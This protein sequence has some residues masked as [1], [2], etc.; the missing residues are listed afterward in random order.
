MSQSL[1]SERVYNF[2]AGP[3]VL[4]EEVL[5]RI[6]DEMMC[7]PGAGSSILEISHR[8]KPFDAI[9]EG[10][11]QRLRQLLSISDDYSVLFL[12]GGSRLQFSM[13]PMNISTAERPGDYL[14][15]GS[16]S[17]KAA[18]EAARLSGGRVIFD[19][20]PDNFCRV[21]ESSE[22]ENNSDRS[23]LYYAANETIQGVQFQDLPDGNDLVSDLSSEFLS[24]P[25][26]VDRHA[27]IYACAQKNAGPAGLTVVIIRKSLLEQVPDNL[28]AYLNFR[29]HDSN[30]SRFNTPPTFAIYVTD[31]VLQWILDKFGSLESMQAHNESKAALLYDV[32]DEFP[33]FYIGHS[34]VESRSRMNVTF[35][36]A[37]EAIGD[38]FKSEAAEHQMQ[39]LGGHRSVGG[40]RASIYNAMPVAGVQ[41][42][43]DFMRDFAK[44]HAS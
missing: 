31:L 43:A 23:F 42:L 36:F 1:V 39:S 27:A 26:D 16:W 41:T 32:I 10:A 6:R 9:L 20:K 37:D 17:Q 8:S 3:A 11:D 35:R 28:P 40:I 14:V 33:E 5:E 38:Q 15:T 24:R 4:P 7:L 12:Q 2:S 30:G 18:A 13:I 22:F 21:P 19:G 34:R 44:K 29:E 25:F